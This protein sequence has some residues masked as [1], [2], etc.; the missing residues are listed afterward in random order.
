Q[1]KNEIKGSIRTESDDVDVSQIA[2][3]FGGGG[4]KKASGFSIPGRLERTGEG[5]WKIIK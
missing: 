4:H 1:E 3:L 5:S 2:S